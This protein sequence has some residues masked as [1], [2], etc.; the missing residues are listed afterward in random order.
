MRTFLP[1]LLALL[2]PLATAASQ[3]PVDFTRTE[4]VVYGRKFG[5]ALTLDVIQPKSPNGYGIVY[6]VSGGWKSNHDSINPNYY[7]PYL[8][9][10]YTIF[11]VCH[12]C[13]PKFTIPEIDEDINR[14][15]RFIR[16]NANRWQVKANHLGVTG[17]SAGGHLS[18]WARKAARAT[19]RPRTRSIAKAAPCRQWPAFIRPPIF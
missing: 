15:V 3:S 14:A 10:G 17:G 2:L 5:V 16:H 18:P 4:D 1:V 9:R 13:Q 6:L 19:P 11:A 7:A 12:G 8:E